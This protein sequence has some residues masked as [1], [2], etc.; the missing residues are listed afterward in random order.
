MLLTRSRAWAAIAALALAAALAL[1]A[2]G[3]GPAT[4]DTAAAHAG[5]SFCH[6]DLVMSDHGAE[7]TCK[8]P[9]Q[10]FPIGVV[11][12][13][14]A[15]DPEGHAEIHVEVFAELSTGF[16]RPLGI[17]CESQGYGAVTCEQS[18]N[19]LGSPLTAPE[20]APAEIVA[21]SCRAHS[22]AHETTTGTPSGQFACW[23]TDEAR[24]SLVEDGFPHRPAS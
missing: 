7:G 8:A 16:A 23:S 2:A 17:E 13:F 4:L 14:D 10:G 5:G 24:E 9:F 22:H 11:G 1:L 15:G 21:L 12:K 19:P 6:G 18:N 3:H 20:P